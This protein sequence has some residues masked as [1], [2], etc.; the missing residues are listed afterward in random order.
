MW[1]KKIKPTEITVGITNETIEFAKEFGEYLAD[2]G[3][4]RD[5]ELKTSQLRK[6]YGE[7]KRQEMTGYNESDFIMLKPKLAYA[8]GRANKGNRIHD[9]YSVMA[10]AIDQVHNEKQFQNFIR[11]FE[12]IVAY[13]KLAESQKK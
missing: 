10:D 9:F 1:S 4:V 7:V 6:F 13:H 3:N 11:I 8:A 5:A 2:N 12:A